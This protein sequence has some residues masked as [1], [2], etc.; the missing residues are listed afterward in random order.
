MNH[1]MAQQI[2]ADDMDIHLAITQLEDDIQDLKCQIDDIN[3][4]AK[5]RGNWTTELAREHQV[6]VSQLREAKD[7]LEIW[8]DRAKS[9]PDF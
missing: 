9:L 3:H 2:T 1:T 6:A 7:E 5:A 8:E 4:E